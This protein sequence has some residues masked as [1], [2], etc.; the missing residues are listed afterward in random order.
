MARPR[1]DQSG[2]AMPNVSIRA[3]R[4]HHDIL[5]Q[6]PALLRTPKG[7]RALSW[8]LHHEVEE[9]VGLFRSEEAALRFLCDAITVACH[10]RAIWLFGSRARGNARPDSDVD[11]LVVLPDGKETGIESD[12]VRATALGGVATDILVCSESEFRD[13]AGEIHTIVG[14]VHEHGRRL[15]ADKATLREESLAQHRGRVAELA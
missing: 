11:L 13:Y 1:L 6:V 3:P 15:Y 10:P 2:E 14:Q 5:R 4:R 12:I 8:V 7:E 9:P